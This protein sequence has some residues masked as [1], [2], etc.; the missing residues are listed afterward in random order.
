MSDQAGDPR[1]PVRAAAVTVTATLTGVTVLVL[2]RL[3]YCRGWEAEAIAA[4]LS[5]VSTGIGVEQAINTA[6]RVIAEQLNQQRAA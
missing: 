2:V 5:L 4:E 1:A 3:L 6:A